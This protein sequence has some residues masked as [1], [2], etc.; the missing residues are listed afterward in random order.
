[1]EEIYKGI[2]IFDGYCN[3]CS[4]SVL[5]IIRRDNKNHFAFAASQADAGQ[6]IV[7]QYRIGELAAHSI[8]LIEDGVIYRRSNAVLRIARRLRGGWPLF[9]ALIILPRKFRD[10]VYDFIAGRRYRIF[11]IRDRCFIPGPGISD[12][13]LDARAIP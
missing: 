10:K 12:R 5:F 7:Y 3:F 6:K 8:L 2:V 9:Y 1:L 13:F 4:R 11:G